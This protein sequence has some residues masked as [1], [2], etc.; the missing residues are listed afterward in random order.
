MNI[1]ALLLTSALTVG[2]TSFA[3]AQDQGTSPPGQTGTGT[4]QELNQTQPTQPLPETQGQTGTDTSQTTPSDQ[5]TTEPVQQGQ[6][7]TQPEQQNQAQSG[8]QMQSGMQSAF[9]LPEGCTQYLPTSAQ[10]QSQQDMSSMQGMSGSGTAQWNEMQRGIHSAM[11]QAMQPSM[12][13]MMNLDT[14]VAF[15]CAMIPHHQAA[16]EMARLAEQQ[17]DNAEAKQF[18]RQ[19]IREQQREID[20]MTQWVRQNAEIESRDE[21]QATGSTTAPAGDMNNMNQ[22]GSGSTG[23][24]TEPQQ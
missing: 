1:R 24:A 17:G 16:I 3:I 12:Q 6:D 15:I 13:G 20:R 14:D 21:L 11:M 4:T 10:N 5:T 2:F 9:N 19:I 18:A 22:S 8:D 7:Q 23:T